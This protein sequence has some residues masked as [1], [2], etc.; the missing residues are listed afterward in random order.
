MPFEYAIM[1]LPPGLRMKVCYMLLSLLIPSS[2]KPEAQKKY[3]D[4]VVDTELNPLLT[5]GIRYDHG[6]ARVMIFGSPLDLP[7]RDKFFRLRG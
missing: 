1:N 2:L 6:I 7:G 3:F 4:Y 5:T